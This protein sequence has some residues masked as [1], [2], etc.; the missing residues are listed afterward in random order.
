MKQSYLII[1]LNCFF[2][3]Q[4][5]AFTGN[6][7]YRTPNSQ[8]EYKLS[9]RTKS[10][11][12]RTSFSQFESS[13][14][15]SSTCSCPSGSGKSYRSFT[16]GI[17]N[18]GLSS[19]LFSQKNKE[20]MLD[21]E[22]DEDDIYFDPAAA[23]RKAEESQKMNIQM[24]V[25]GIKK[26]ASPHPRVALAAKAE[27]KVDVPSLTHG[28]LYKRLGESDLIVSEVCL[29][30]MTWGEQN[31]EEEAHS[32]L[33]MA[34]KEF[35]VNFID[36]AELYPVPANPETQGKTD[37]YISSWLK[38]QKREDLILASKVGGR[39]DVLTWLRKDNIP[40]RLTE[41]Q[42]IESVESSLT[43]LGTDYI[44]LLQIHW[45]DRY[46]PLFG[47]G[48]YDAEKES[49]DIIPIHEQLQALSKLVKAGKI[50]A[51]GLSNETPYGIMSFLQAAKEHGLEKIVSVQNCY[52]L[53][54]RNEIETSMVEVCSPRHCNVG[55]LAYSPLAGG[56]LTGKYLS[57]NPANARLNLFPG[58]MERFKQTLATECL[59]E[60][61]TISE[62]YGLTMTQMALAWSY[63]QPFITSTII[64]ATT[65]EQL[66]E[67][68]L[69]LN[70]PITSEIRN[71][72]N[73]VFIRYR[74]P[75]RQIAAV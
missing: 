57:E 70:V 59:Y 5:L 50:R 37:K 73:E 18:R 61:K 10:Q 60:Y 31:T 52:N 66:K 56:A 20:D 4:V 74:D 26:E 24:E 27:K 75:T 32:Q 51:I 28:M 8:Q 43:R 36:T 72:L 41:K 54:S 47:L 53:I 22:E 25:M 16:N 3:V 17:R 69:A 39:S 13:H 44:D 7:L 15:Y 34:V 19:K 23:K 62:N 21:E 64:G 33:D 68:I 6:L 38:K 55:I 65:T 30:T 11:L 63:S 29:G 58:Y 9:P 49:D 67:N 42:I 48:I 71:D 40:V 14:S 12:Q 1:L 35:G 46:V 45:P 2:L